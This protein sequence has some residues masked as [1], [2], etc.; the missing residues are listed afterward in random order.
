[1]LVS[2]DGWHTVQIDVQ[3]LFSRA[4][5]PCFFTRGDLS[6]RAYPSWWHALYKEFK[7]F[8]LSI[9]GGGIPKKGMLKAST[10]PRPHRNDGAILFG[11]TNDNPNRNRRRQPVDYEPVAG[12]FIT[13]ETSNRPPSPAR[14]RT[15]ES[16]SKARTRLF[17]IPQIGCNFSP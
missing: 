17:H 13:A 14:T 7:S 10:A 16:L 6:R 12:S 11:P 1:M 4:A 9:G 5:V 2:T 8:L 3:F 15:K